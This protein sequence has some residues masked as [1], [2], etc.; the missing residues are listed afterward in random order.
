MS[1]EKKT[2]LTAIIISALLFSAVAGTEFTNLVK[3]NP[4]LYY[5]Y[6]SPPAYVQPP[7]IAIFYPEN[8]TVFDS[9]D[10]F[11]S[12]N[13]TM[14]N[15]TNKIT[16]VW[17]EADWRGGNKTVYRL[18]M[19]TTEYIIRRSWI[20]EFSYNNTLRGI[21]E[22]KHSIK[23]IASANGWYAVG[24]SAYEF[25]IGGSSTVEFTV[26]T[27]PPKVSVLSVQNVTYDM[28]YINLIFTVS[29]PVSQIVYRLDGQENVTVAGNTTLTNLSYGEHSVTVYATDRV[30]HVGASESINFVVEETFPTTMVV[31]PE[32]SVAVLGV[33]LL[34]YFRK[35]RR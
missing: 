1:V 2:L 7:V 30:G 20:T 12:F 14:S 19:S 3:A 28:N 26:D 31:A 23:V 16:T 32:E 35:R 13:V 33:G 18:D 17:L 29:E 34:A 8:N 6:S 25:D 15:S 22:G 9:N 4:Y 5:G 21:P 27:S 11:L 24:M 10:V